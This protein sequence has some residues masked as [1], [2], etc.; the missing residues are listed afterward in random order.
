MATTRP[1]FRLV[2]FSVTVIVGWVSCVWRTVDSD[3]CVD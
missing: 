1:S 3:L 2:G